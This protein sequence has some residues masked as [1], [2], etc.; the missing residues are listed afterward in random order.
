M[1]N[2]IWFIAAV[3]KDKKITHKVFC[4]NKYWNKSKTGT[5][6]FET[7]EEAEEKLKEIK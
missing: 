3:L 2:R 7:K 6:R 4:G 5:L 1:D